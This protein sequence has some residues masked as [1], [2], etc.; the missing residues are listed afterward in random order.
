MSSVSVTLARRSPSNVA[1]IVYSEELVPDWAQNKA[2]YRNLYGED[3]PGDPER[4]TRRV[5]TWIKLIGDFCRIYRRASFTIAELQSAFE[6]PLDDSSTALIRPRGFPQLFQALPAA[7]LSCESF[8][9]AAERANAELACPPGWGVW[10]FQRLV[11]APARSALSSLLSTPTSVDPAARHVFVPY[12]DQLWGD[13]RPALLEATLDVVDRVFPA[14]ELS[15]RAQQQLGLAEQEAE[16][17]LLHMV[18]LGAAVRFSHGNLVGYKLLDAGPHDPQV[19]AGILHVKHQIR[20]S[21]ALVA[22]LAVEIAGETKAAVEAKQRGEIES[23]KRRLKHRALL[24]RMA[25][26]REEILETFRTQLATVR[27]AGSMHEILQALQ[28]GSG[29]L[30]AIQSRTPLDHIADTLT[31]VESTLQTQ[32]ELD[33]VITQRLVSFSQEEE[34]ELLHELSALQEEEEDPVLEFPIAPTA[35]IPIPTIPI[36]NSS[37]PIC[38]SSSLE[39]IP[40]LAM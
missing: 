13:L 7:I 32:R 26:E 4:R 16:L 35:V 11:A 6:R 14:P 17:L 40:E 2:T 37:Q 30:E 10:L 38:S 12:L 19:D 23:A 34:E 39:P 9:G 33:Q 15:L 3:L 31:D 1:L 28:M 27:S 24:R 8:S 22:R 5:E 25:G 36:P 18:R 21:E 29:A 20:Q